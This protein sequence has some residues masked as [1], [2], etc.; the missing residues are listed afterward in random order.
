MIY[1][2][3]T[4]FLSHSS[5]T[6]SDPLSDILFSLGTGS[7]RC[8]RLEA[9]GVWGL[10][11]PAQPRLKFVAV[12]RGACFVLLPHR[13]PLPCREGDVFLIGNTEYAVASGPDAPLIDGARLYARPEDDI[14]RLGG[15]DT[16]LIGG[17]VS[18]VDG[19]IGLVLDALPDFLRIERASPAAEAV[20]RT[21]ELLEREVGRGLFGGALITSRLAE[22]MLVEAIR[23]SVLDRGMAGIGW[24]GALGDHQI[25]RALTLMHSEVDRDWTVAK[26]AAEVG[27]S[28]S[29]F[30]ARFAELVGKPPIVYLTHW[31]MMLARRLLRGGGKDVGSVARDVGYTSQ[32]A[33][34]HAFK[35]AFGYPPRW[36]Q[37]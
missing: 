18:G 30:S 26:L 24:I 29:G 23:A 21:L 9:S 17:G 2:Q 4:M 32:S 5:K 16:V 20:G 7:I 1:A 13:A 33:F 3:L 34:G 19:E 35:R 31:R 12:S 28:R 14:V 25:G 37:R 15:D 22:V 36:K 11:F 27:M 10:S 8:T 6:S